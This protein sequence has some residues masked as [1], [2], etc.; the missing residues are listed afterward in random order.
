MPTPIR[1]DLLRH[2]H[3]TFTQHVLPSIQDE[4]QKALGLTILARSYIADLAE[5]SKNGDSVGSIPVDSLPWLEGVEAGIRYL[6][7]AIKASQMQTPA[8]A[9][10]L[11]SH[12]LVFLEETE[13]LTQDEDMKQYLQAQLERV[14]SRS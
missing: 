14:S 11:R 4:N 10:A 13:G 2:T 12:L 8:T 1:V 7:R 6:R 9:T 3:D 5:P